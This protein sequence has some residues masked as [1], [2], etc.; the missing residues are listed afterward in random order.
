MSSNGSIA[1]FCCA[2][3]YDDVSTSSRDRTK[4]NGFVKFVG[5]LWKWIMWH[6]KLEISLA[7]IASKFWELRIDGRNLNISYVQKASGLRNTHFTTLYLQ[8][9]SETL[10]IVWALGKLCSHSSF[11]LASPAHSRAT[12]QLTKGAAKISGVDTS[13]LNGG[14]PKWRYLKQPKS[15]HVMIF[16]KVS[17]PMVWGIPPLQETPRQ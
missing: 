13:S 2:D 7:P 9:T 3:D 12:Q 5:N 14:F 4:Q 17:K 1:C 16:S 6:I 15:D 10:R 11:L 8:F